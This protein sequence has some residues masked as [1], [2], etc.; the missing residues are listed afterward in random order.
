M[1]IEWEGRTYDYDP[2]SVLMSQA[3][4]ILTYTGCKTLGEWEELLLKVDD[5]KFPQAV[6]AAYWL[7]M[8]QAGH[9]GEIGAVD[10]PFL[11]FSLAFIAG[12]KA[13]A[14]DEQQAA[15]ADPTNGAAPHGGT[16]PAPEAVSAG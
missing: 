2:L 8:C 1:K 15:E 16:S 3:T 11:R 13:A 5:A 9:G 10:I 7:M 14:A 6:T 12:L 4:Q